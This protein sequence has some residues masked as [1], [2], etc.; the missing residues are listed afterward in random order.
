M[1]EVYGK[2]VV[3]MTKRWWFR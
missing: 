1:G 2:S 3:E